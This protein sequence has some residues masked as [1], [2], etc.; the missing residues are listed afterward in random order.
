M[1]SPDI[2]G[3]WE[4]IGDVDLWRQ[5]RQLLDSRAGAKRRA[6]RRF[7]LTGGI[8]TC[9]RCG[10][11]TGAQQRTQLRPKRIRAVYFCKPPS[12]GGCS[13]LCIGADELEA[14]VAGKLFDELETHPEFFAALADTDT[15]SERQRIEAGLAQ[16]ELDRA[17]LAR[18]RAR[19]EV[20]PSEWQAMREVYDVE[21]AKLSAELAAL[22][23]PGVEVDPAEVRG[24]WENMTL[25]ERR[26]LIDM[27]VEKV[28]IGPA[29]P[30][31]RRFDPERVSIVWA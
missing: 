28:V 15:G 14:H 21:Q 13:R 4:P 27:Y 8:A 22:P 3:T 9:G 7:L 10:A 5:V 30:G 17:D 19:R 2:V 29:K 12:L 11:G 24:A 23:A 16:V 18:M 25:D 26:E 6:R 31:T 20:T 1:R